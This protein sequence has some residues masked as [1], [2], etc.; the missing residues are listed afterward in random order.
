MQLLDQHAV[1]GVGAELLDERVLRDRHELGREVDVIARLLVVDLPASA[2]RGR[3][4][5]SAS[6]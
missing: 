1:D 3:W 4:R 6:R 2:S 5:A